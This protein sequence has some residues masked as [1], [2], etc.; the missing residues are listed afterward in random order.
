[1][2]RLGLKALFSHWRR[3]PLQLFAFLAG[4]A[5]ATALWT[6]VEAINAEAR[7]SYDNA[8]RTLAGPGLARI[9]P[10]SGALT[11]AD[12]LTLRRNGWL[13]S[14]I[15]EGSF[16]TGGTLRLVGIDPFTL[17]RGGPVADGIASFD[18]GFLQGQLLAAPATVALLD[19]QGGVAALPGLP[20]GTVYADIDVARG[21]L[22]RPGAIDALV[23]SDRQPPGRPALADIAPRLVIEAPP[24][25]GDLGRLTDSFHLNLTAFG[26]LSFVVGLFIV[27]GAVGLAFE[28]RRPMF[29]TLRALGLPLRHLIALLMAELLLLAAV[30]GGL[31]VFLGWLVAAALMPDISATL[32]GVFGAPV[33]GELHLAPGWLAGGLGIALAGALVAGAGSV[34]QLAHLSV[35]APARPRAWAMASDRAIRLQALAACGLIGLAAGVFWLGS[36]LLAAFAVLAAL[37]LGAA[38]ALPMLLAVALRLAGARART[39]LA[40][41]F[42][43]DAQHGLRGLSLAL[44]ALMLALAAN[45]GVGSMVQ[46]FRATFA[47]YLDQRLASELYIR[48]AD[49]RQAAAIAQWLKPRVDAVLPIWSVQSRVGGLPAD[50]FGVADHAT[51]RDHWPLL[52]ADA[53]VWDRLAAGD[54]VLVNEQLA[55]RRD[56]WVGATV[57]LAGWRAPVLGVYSD[58][59]N[60]Q[61]QII[62]GQE[63]FLRRFPGADRRRMGV[64]IAPAGLPALRAALRAEF[65]LSGEAMVDQASLKAFSLQIFERTF[66]VTAALNVLTMG[67]AALAM[68]FSLLTLSGLRIPQLAPVWAAGVTRRR[69]SLF[70]LMRA[71]VLAGLTLALA[72]P[73]GLV[74]AWLLLAL[75]NVEAFGW[76][77]P[78]QLFPGDWLRLAGLAMLA[79]TAAAAWP[80][81]AIA[82]LSP[83]A[84]LQVFSSAR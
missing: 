58:Y 73:V 65:G 2:L 41:W 49:A 46:S 12:F 37:L 66:A 68:L 52:Q 47:G 64:R 70:E 39:P 30:A 74:L 14:P 18:M 62:L 28:Q 43:A 22:A 63:A 45:V 81:L 21:L 29:R 83:A 11:G 3:H 84:L 44:M 7:S 54:G 53:R 61:A 35:L 60:N 8:A 82:R 50:I 33:S 1:M 17:P 16:G 56:L 6:G 51:Y 19:G 15:V 26:L 57:D 48:A 79:A 69:L 34:W 67:V 4:M 9:V 10:V 78:M 77:I 24:S 40:R 32:R 13:V 5:A 23:L 38:L 59:G 55:R 72:L 25:G 80:A 31:G 42:W 76:R 36:G 27:R 20:D 75:V 71:L